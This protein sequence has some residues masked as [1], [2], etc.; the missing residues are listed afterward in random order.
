MKILDEKRGTFSYQI[1]ETHPYDL[2]SQKQDLLVEMKKSISTNILTEEEEKQP[3]GARKRKPNEK[4][5]ENMIQKV[6]DYTT[7]RNDFGK[8][9]ED[10]IEQIVAELEFLD[11]EADSSDHTPV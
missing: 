1:I 11:P 9:Y 6:L 7:I 5:H 8:E 10:S 3:R 2:T 4:K